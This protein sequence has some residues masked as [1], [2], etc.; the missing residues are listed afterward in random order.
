M[1][2]QA[3]GEQSIDLEIGGVRYKAGTV[4]KVINLDAENEVRQHNRREFVEA[5]AALGSLPTDQLQRAIAA[6]FDVM[7]RSTIV[8][9]YETTAWMTSASGEAFLLYRSLLKYQADM[10]LEKARELYGQMMPLD[11]ARL[12]RFLTM[13]GK[14][15]RFEEAPSASTPPETTEAAA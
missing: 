4:G 5:V 1:G 9:M 3:V 8:P 10:T 12:D 15:Q 7:L 6:A 11:F 2:E 14:G 13:T